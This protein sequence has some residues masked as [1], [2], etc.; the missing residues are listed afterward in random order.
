VRTVASPST[1]SPDGGD[2]AGSA[3]VEA[4]VALVLI[5]TAGLVVA[6]AATAGLRAT[7]RAATLAG[8]TGV[9]ERELALAANA[10]ATVAA[11]T[12]TLAVS[13]FPAPVSRVTA[14][15]RGAG[16]VR[17]AVTVVGGRPPERVTLATSVGMPP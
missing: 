14:V 8:V 7:R 6:T 15:E 9:A 5:A 1:A 3:L 16:V 17:I 4:L 10:A 11:D 2:S 12:A 13:G